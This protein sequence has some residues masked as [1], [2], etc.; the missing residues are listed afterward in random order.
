[1]LPLLN[2]SWQKYK[3]SFTL[4]ELLITIVILSILGVIGLATFTGYN[5][6]ARDSTRVED[7]ANI[8]KSLAIYITTTGNR[9]PLPDN[10]VPV[11]SG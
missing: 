2:T 4:V 11:Y 10:G 1:M 8:Q 5:S 7:L 6:N 3:H 9:Y